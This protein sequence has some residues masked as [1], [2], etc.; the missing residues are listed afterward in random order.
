MQD[1]PDDTFGHWVHTDKKKSPTL[2]CPRG[3]RRRRSIPLRQ[4]VWSRKDVTESASVQTASLLAL[5]LICAMQVL[6]YCATILPFQ[7]PPPPA[8]SRWKKLFNTVNT[9]RRPSPVPSH[10]RRCRENAKGYQRCQIMILTI[11]EIKDGVNGPILLVGTYSQRPSSEFAG[12]CWLLASQRLETMSGQSSCPRVNIQDLQE[13]KK[14]RSPWRSRIPSGQ[15]TGKRVKI[16]VE[17][18]W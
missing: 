6:Q 16:L 2:L 18:R 5:N 10:Q 11:P 4:K 13:C 3:Q 12:Q 17:L 8:I 9:A 1:L 7:T 15:P 14:R